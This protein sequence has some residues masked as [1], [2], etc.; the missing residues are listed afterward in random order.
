MKGTSME[1]YV[2]TIQDRKNPHIYFPQGRSVDELTWS[3]L[4][5]ARGLSAVG[6]VIPPLL[7]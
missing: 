4:S 1:A 5:G 6:W 7:P 3:F 2:G